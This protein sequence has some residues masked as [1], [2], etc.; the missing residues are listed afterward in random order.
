MPLGLFSWAD[1]LVYGDLVSHLAGLFS[2]VDATAISKALAVLLTLL[3]LRLVMALLSGMQWVCESRAGA[4]LQPLCW[5]LL[6]LVDWPDNMSE[7]ISTLVLVAAV[8]RLLIVGSEVVAV[9]AR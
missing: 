3:V 9:H 4:V 1:H 8:N 7:V 2:A 5:P 6:H